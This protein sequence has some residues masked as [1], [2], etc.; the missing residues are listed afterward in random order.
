MLHALLC[1]DMYDVRE[2][3]EATDPPDFCLQSRA[4]VVNVRTPGV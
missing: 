1:R 4:F 3:S 2:V